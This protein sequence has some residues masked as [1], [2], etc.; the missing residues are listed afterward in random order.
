MHVYADILCNSPDLKT[1]MQDLQKIF[2]RLTQA[3]LTLK[4]SKCQIAAQQVKYL[5]HIL[6][7]TGILPNPNKVSVIKKHPKPK[8]VK[9]AADF[10]AW[11]STIAGS[12]KIVLTLPN[13][14]KI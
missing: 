11:P 6:S 8:N 5:G 14:S 2:D 7:P 13:L 3:G 9:E 1:H 10:G 12:W 4:P